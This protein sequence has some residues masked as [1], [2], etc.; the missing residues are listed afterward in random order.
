M[1]LINLNFS[2]Q[3]ISNVAPVF[4]VTVAVTEP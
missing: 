4:T 1:K 3:S 2:Y